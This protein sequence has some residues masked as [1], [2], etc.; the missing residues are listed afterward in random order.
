M[1]LRITAIVLVL[2]LAACEHYAL[3]PPTRTTIHQAFTVEPPRPWNR[4]SFTFE[5]ISPFEFPLH[6]QWPGPVETWTAEGYGLDRIIFVAGLTSGSPL[7]KED[8][9]KDPIPKFRD[10]MTA[11]E[12]MEF[13]EASLART[14]QTTLIETKNLRPTQFGGVDGFR[15]DIRYVRKDDEVDTDGIVVGAV[16][17]KKLYLIFFSGT[18]LYHYS[19][20][21]PDVEKLI[22]SVKFL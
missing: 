15:F 16:R 22:A 8:D 20:L 3:V 17:N 19:K 5:K 1:T 2:A 9:S 14:A 11:S 18:H 13:F 7:I 4:W 6:E 21:L 10:D 12:I